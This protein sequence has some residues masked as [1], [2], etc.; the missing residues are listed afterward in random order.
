M[1]NIKPD[2]GILTSTPVM[3][4]RPMASPLN[5]EPPQHRRIK[6]RKYS[7]PHDIQSYVPPSIKLFLDQPSSRSNSPIIGPERTGSCASNKASDEDSIPDEIELPPQAAL[8]KQSSATAKPF[9]P[10]AGETRI[11]PKT[12]GSGCVTKKTLDST[13]YASST[14]MTS[15]GSSCNRG[16]AAEEG[17]VSGQCIGLLHLL[18]AE[19]K[20]PSQFHRM[21]EAKL[22]A[23]QN[24]LNT[25]N[26]FPLIMVR[27]GKPA[28]GAKKPQMDV[29]RVRKNLL[30]I[31]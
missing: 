30:G 6:T 20:K 23:S 9:S 17:K 13:A 14:V 11:L 26:S 18:S 25:L 5:L 22:S 27:G 19:L 10:G 12:P 21:E 24:T 29:S 28:E 7:N 31:H 16:T 4:Y 1:G 3:T 8:F 15:R 2:F